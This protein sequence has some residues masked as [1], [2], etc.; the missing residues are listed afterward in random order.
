[1]SDPLSPSLVR[2]VLAR[3]LSLNESLAALGMTSVRAEGAA[4]GVKR[5]MRDGEI[6]FTGDARDGWRWLR[7][8]AD[9]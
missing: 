9:V 4:I 3:D 8:V 6:V 2:S 5:F 1:M 7:E